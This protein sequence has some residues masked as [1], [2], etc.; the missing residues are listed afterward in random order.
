MIDALFSPAAASRHPGL[1]DRIAHR[2]ALRRQRRVLADMSP[3]RLRDIGITA[4]QAQSETER[5][6]WDVPVYWLR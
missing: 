3:Q 4:E 2:I 6:V 1:L 5:P